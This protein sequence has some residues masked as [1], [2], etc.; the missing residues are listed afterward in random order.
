LVGHAGQVSLG[1]AAFFAIGAYG[2][3]VA[4]RCGGPSCPVCWR[5]PESRPSSATCSG[6]LSAPERLYLAMATLG[7]TLIVQEMLLSSP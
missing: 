5:R 2:R 7:F 3:R 1:H 6:C 4:S